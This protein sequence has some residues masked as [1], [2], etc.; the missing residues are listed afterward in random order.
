L[1]RAFHKPVYLILHGA[2]AAKIPSINYGSLRKAVLGWMIK[3]SVRWAKQLLP[4]S[5]YILKT[6]L[7]EGVEK[8]EKEQGILS[9]CPNLKTPIQVISNGFDPDFWKTDKSKKDEKLIVAMAEPHQYTLKGIDLIESA[10]KR[11]PDFQFE[12]IGLQ[13]ASYPKSRLAN[14]TYLPFL[15]RNKVRTKFSEAGIYL[16]MSIWE[17]FGC[18]LCEAMLCHCVPIVFN[19]NMLPQIVGD[20]RYVIMKRSAKA[21]ADKVLEVAKESVSDN[22]KQRIR[23]RI[24]SNFHIK[25]R[26]AMLLD[27]LN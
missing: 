9:F 21:L 14:V 24:V 12:I 15:T 1:G 3:K 16:Q 4:V 13:S 18:A 22:E 26:E 6:N 5:Q 7:L 25:T 8:N 11:L 27:I 19:V 20:Q 17:G 23:N 2:D 10:A